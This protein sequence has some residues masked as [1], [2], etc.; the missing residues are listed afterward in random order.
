VDNKVRE[1]PDDPSKDTVAE[2]EHGRWSWRAVLDIQE[3]LE[4]SNKRLE[5]YGIPRAPEDLITSQ[6]EKEVRAYFNFSYQDIEANVS[7]LNRQ[8]RE[9]FDQVV[10]AVEG[11]KAGN[12][13]GSTV[14]F[15]DGV[16][17][18]GKT[19]LYKT[20]LMR[21]RRQSQEE[22]DRGER[23]VAIAMASNG[24]PAQL[25]PNGTTVHRRFKLPITDDFEGQQ[26]MCGISRQSEEADLLRKARLIVWDEA[27]TMNKWQ[28]DAVH[29]C[30]RDVMRQPDKVMG[31]KVVVLGGDFR[32]CGP[33]LKNSRGR[34]RRGSEVNASLTHWNNW[35]AVKVLRLHINMR[36]ENCER[37]GRKQRLA[38][39]SRW[40]KSIGDGDVPLD[41]NGR[42]EVPPSIA[43]V[44]SEHDPEIRESE[45]LE[46]MYS[47]LRNKEGEDRDEFL[48]GTAVLVP[49][50][51]TAARVND[52]LLD[53]LID[54]Q[55][56][57]FVSINGTADPEHQRDDAYPEEY[58][59][60][61]K[62]S[63]LPAHVL[64]LKVGA[65]IIAL[66]NITKGVSNGTR[67]V[68]T[69][70]HK[71]SI[72]ARVLHGA[73]A[74]R[75]ILIS[76]VEMTQD[77]GSFVIKRIQLPIRVAFA[78]TINKAQGLT[79]KRV[80][81]YLKDDVFSHGQLYVALSRC[82]DQGNLRIFGPEPD[83]QGRAWIKNVVYKEVLIDT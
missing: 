16:G 20:M 72:R 53:T 57:R 9:A 33:V 2:D 30:L 31:G 1:H 65:P 52:E 45:F 12:Y 15:L 61:I 13:D 37:A 70:I 55:G 40:L 3:L 35:G 59:A 81:V 73:S 68:V 69:K 51:D 18:S 7:K 21:V 54:A 14:F 56:H 29:R 8:Q 78:I 66:R 24:L 83:E 4:N 71:L 67:M 58:L 50:N 74:G 23:P 32:Q 25:L 62:E 5:E 49:K 22:S 34:G 64:T 11:T 63:S 27:P 26:L 48:K 80:G 76:R 6:V 77:M 41:E 79:L 42:L 28:L 17:G 19:F 46:Y 47:E 43:F 60:S 75:E 44:S 36:V 10:A 39:W 38:E 82:G